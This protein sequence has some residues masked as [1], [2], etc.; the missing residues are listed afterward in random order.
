[1]A[2]GMM[3]NSNKSAIYFPKI[4]EDIKLLLTDLFTFP[5]FELADRLKYLGFYLKPNNYGISYWKWL[6]KRI[7]KRIN[8]WCNRWIS[9]GGRLMLIKSIIEA[10]LVYWHLLAY[11]PKGILVKIRKICFNYLWKGSGEYQE[12]HLVSWKVLISTQ[13]VQ[14]LGFKGHMSVWEGFGDETL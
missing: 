14:W 12:S 4:E 11:I 7:E 10:I 2:T 3:V 6:L 5:S 13:M 1:M 8:L 9:R